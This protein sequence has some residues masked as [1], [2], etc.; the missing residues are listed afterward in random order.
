MAIPYQ[1]AKLKSANVLAI[2]IL[3][4]TALIPANLFGYMVL[5]HI[6]ELL[7]DQVLLVAKAYM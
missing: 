4:S 3:G 7:N 5:Y 6:T 1:T 2:A